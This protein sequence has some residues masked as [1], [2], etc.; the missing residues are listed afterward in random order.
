MSR[1]HG[2]VI[3]YAKLSGFYP[4]I[5]T[6]SPSNND[7]VTSLGATHPLDRN[8]PLSTLADSI[9]AITTKPVTVI[10]DAI[11]IPETQN[12]AYK[13]LADGGT[14]ILVLAAAVKDEDKVKGKDIANPYGSA[15]SQGAFGKEVY[16]HLGAYLEN[17][18]IKVR[19]SMV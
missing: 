14:L 4:I 17:G 6:V 5:T 10:Y 7:L 15:P 2:T 3:Q 9:K 19:G 16:A 13:I 11:S 8:K 12:A 18:D 1:A